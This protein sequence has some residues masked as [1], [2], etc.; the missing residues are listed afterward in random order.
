MLKSRG[1]R[2]QPWR[3]PL[4]MTHGTAVPWPVLKSVATPLLNYEE[5]QTDCTQL[6]SIAQKIAQIAPI[7][8]LDCITIVPF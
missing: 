2:E 1:D 7:N 4:P 3:I 6:H 8:V 5:R